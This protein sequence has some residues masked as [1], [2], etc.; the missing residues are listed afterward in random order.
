MGVIGGGFLTVCM[1]IIITKFTNAGDI[2]TGVS[3]AIGLMFVF[4][5]YELWFCW[6]G[7]K[8]GLKQ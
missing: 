4:Y 2:Q 3:I 5:L 7:S 8:V 1:G 6:K